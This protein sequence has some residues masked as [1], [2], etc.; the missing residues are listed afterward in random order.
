MCGKK[1]PFLGISLIKGML[2]KEFP[3]TKGISI[4]LSQ[5]ACFF[6][7]FPKKGSA[8]MFHAENPQ[9]NKVRTKYFSH[10]GYGFVYFLSHNGYALSKLL[11]HKRPDFE[12]RYR[13]YLPLLDRSAPPPSPRDIDSRTTPPPPSGVQ[14][15]IFLL[16]R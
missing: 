13:T 14:M 6:S 4:S 1:A 3:F 5:R 16:D 11:S 7:E 2:F 8:E 15:Y 12:H 10:K 9:K